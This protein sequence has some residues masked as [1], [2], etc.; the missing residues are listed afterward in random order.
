MKWQI[1]VLSALL[2]A[3]AMADRQSFPP[4]NQAAIG[5]RLEAFRAD[6]LDK[7]TARDT[8]AVVATACPD[9]YLSHGGNGGPDE[10]RANLDLDPESLTEDLRPQAEMLRESYWQSLQDTLAQPGYFDEDGEFW[11]PHQWRLSLPA[12]LDPFETYFVTGENVTLRQAPSRAGIVLGLISY[13]VVIIKKYLDDKAYQLVRLTDGTQGYI[14]S[15][16]LWSMVGYRAALVK[17]ETGKWQLCTFVTG[18]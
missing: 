2:C 14:N 6:L 5:A 16:Y 10:L 11:M 17:S 1:A 3:P 12:S 4:P 7:V 9:I 8:D 15:D 13:E 18:D